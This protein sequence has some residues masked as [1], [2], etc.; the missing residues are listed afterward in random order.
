MIVLYLLLHLVTVT[1][2]ILI[3]C[4]NVSYYYFE[5]EVIQPTHA[6][7]LLFAIT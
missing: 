5:I 2:L 3:F 4:L 7:A 6:L 1:Q